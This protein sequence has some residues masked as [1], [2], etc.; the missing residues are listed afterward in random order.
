[1]TTCAFQLFF[2][3]IYTFFSIKYTF[4]SA[5]FLFE[6]GSVV[7][8]A[9]PT[10]N[11]FIIGRAIAGLGSAGLFS[12]AIL[13]VAYTVPLRQRPIYTGLIG[14]MYGIASVAGPLLGGAF[15]D[16]VSWRWCFY[17]NLPIG[18]LTVLFIVIFFK[19]PVRDHED[20]QGWKQ[21]IGMLDLEG[22]WVF[23]PG[24]VCLLLALQWGGSK[25]PW[26]N[27]RII[28]LFILFGL[29]I[30]A[31]IG[32]QIYKGEL[33]TVPPR[34][35]KQRSV[36]SSAWFA[37]CLG[38][39]F[40]TMIYYIPIWFQAIKG[41]TAVKSGIMNLPM[42]LGLILVSILS[43]AVVTKVGYY[44]PFVIASTLFMSVGAGL[45]TTFQTDTGHSKWIGYQVMFGVGV[46]FGMQQAL[47]AVQTVLPLKDVP[48]GTAIIMFSQTLGG[49]LF[50]SVGQ[51]VFTNELIKNV[52]QT[53]PDLNPAA[54]VS[55]GA[56]Q[57]K[58]LIPSQD[59][60]QV[61]VAYNKT[62]TQVFYVSVATSVLTLLGSS[63]MEWKSVKGKKIEMA[64]A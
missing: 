46:G 57:L 40:F 23:I 61:L 47:I 52:I 16:H 62:I 18:A 26:D 8:G 51:N 43:G 33:A 55:V 32:I 19:S 21:R 53:V 38:A 28:L 42:V 24:V 45:L 7:C 41:V 44:M 9:A 56:T 11:A 5:L 36:W 14:G 20:N 30:I 49:A 35:L 58:N 59:Y 60:Q 12:G 6:L 27:W 31:F 22:T 37:A 4:L 13:I 54:V 17:I 34:V 1:M 29:L 15:T 48:V 64:A 2:G 39:A 63:V 3:K 50:V 10:S 25:Y